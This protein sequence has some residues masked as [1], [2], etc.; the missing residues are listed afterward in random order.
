MCW[1]SLLREVVELPSPE[2]FKKKADVALKAT[3]QCY[4]GHGLTAGLDDLRGL[5]PTLMI[6]HLHN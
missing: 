3:V 6:L 5:S 1:H 4:G 2:V